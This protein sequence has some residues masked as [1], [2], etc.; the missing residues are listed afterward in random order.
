MI[1]NVGKAKSSYFWPL[2][3]VGA[4]RPCGLQSGIASGV[5]GSTRCFSCIPAM[6]YVHDLAHVIDYPPLDL[7]EDLSYDEYQR[8]IV[9]RQVKSLRNHSISYVKVMLANHDDQEATWELESAM[10][11][12]HPHLFMDKVCK[13][14]VSRTKCR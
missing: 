3:A 13:I 1:W 8:K 9:D 11:E 4:G 7:W 12:R 5:G 10:W 6:P 2:C 14:L